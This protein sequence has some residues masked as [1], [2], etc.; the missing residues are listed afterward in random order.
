MFKKESFFLIWTVIRFEYSSIDC[1]F[2]RI[3]WECLIE[4]NKTQSGKLFY[5]LN[6]IESAIFRIFRTH[7]FKLRTIL[8][9]GTFYQNK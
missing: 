3:F 4:K 9:F 1:G 8:H 2:F 7:F 6:I 5:A